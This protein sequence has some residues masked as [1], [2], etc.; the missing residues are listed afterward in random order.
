MK[1]LVISSITSGLVL[2]QQTIPGGAINGKAIPASVFT[3]ANV[4]AQLTDT[5][6]GAARDEA[7]R[8]MGIT[9][10]PEDIAAVRQTMDNPDPAAESKRIIEHTTLM[11]AALAAV[12]RGQDS[13]QVYTT[14]L[15]P[16]GVPE[17]EWTSYQQQWKDPAK[18]ARIERRLAI[19][20]DVIAK[21]IAAVDYR[22]MAIARK[23]DD[24]VDQLLAKGDPQFRTALDHWNASARAVGPGRVQH[25]GPAA[26]Q[27]Y[28]EA[29]RALWWKSRVSKLNVTLNDQTLHT[30]CGLA[31]TG[32]A[33]PFPIIIEKPL[34]LIGSARAR[35]G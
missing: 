16:K 4:C 12:D 26:E 2:A 6:R 20:P 5:I 11:I 8:D 21:G 13:E 33:T 18:R 3:A 29:Q 14:M 35:N 30:K 1:T 9:V 10:T 32:V 15:Q 31:G 25:S 19:T 28:I 24:A 7:V 23:L 22:P 17:Q 34:A 27:Q